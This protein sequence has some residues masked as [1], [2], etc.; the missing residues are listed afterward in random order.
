MTETAV[1]ELTLEERRAYVAWMADQ[2]GQRPGRPGRGV[3]GAWDG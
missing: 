3:G 1:G 2:L